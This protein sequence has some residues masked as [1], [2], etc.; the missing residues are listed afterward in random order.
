MEG[1][2]V[3]EA[4]YGNISSAWIDGDPISLTR[5]GKIIDHLARKKGISDALVSEGTKVPKSH[6]APV[7]VRMQISAA[8]GVLLA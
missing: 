4:K 5:F 7:E 8:G 6:L 2:A 1:A 3:D